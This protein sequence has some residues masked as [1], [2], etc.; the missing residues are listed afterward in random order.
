MI[1]MGFVIFTGLVVLFFISLAFISRV[2]DWL[3]PIIRRMPLFHGFFLPGVFFHELSHYV[4]CI[5]VSRKVTSA[6]F[7]KF[8][9]STG[10]LGSVSFLSG[11]TPRHW[12]PNM[13]IG[14]APLISSTLLFMYLFKDISV[15]GSSEIEIVLEQWV[16]AGQMLI[17][18]YVPWWLILI[19][20]SVSYSSLPSKQDLKI[21][22]NG[23][24]LT[25][26]VLLLTSILIGSEF[27]SALNLLMS[28]AFI[29]LLS[30]SIPSVLL[31]T[32]VL[33]FSTLWKLVFPKR[34]VKPIN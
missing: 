8:D 3:Y 34:V 32:M 16:I 10:N 13:L 7:Y 28:Y 12:I 4:M 15:T 25:Y 33:S 19:V 1:P 30:I 24:L 29:R 6:K 2:Q 5:I 20:F 22:V 31:V 17:N 26:I 18:G 21:S 27:T 9:H 23:L 14:I 11:T